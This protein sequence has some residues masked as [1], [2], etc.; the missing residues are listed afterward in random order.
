LEGSPFY[1]ID[2]EDMS[3]RQLTFFLLM[4]V[5]NVSRFGQ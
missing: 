2:D 5:L 4:F 1:Y 3:S